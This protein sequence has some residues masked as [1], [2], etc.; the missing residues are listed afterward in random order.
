M[1][2]LARAEALTLVFME[3]ESSGVLSALW[4][5]DGL[6]LWV[7]PIL[8]LSF[9]F[10]VSQHELIHGHPFR[11]GVSQQRFGPFGFS[12]VSSLL[13]VQIVSLEHHA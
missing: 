9:A 1:K 13:Q 3:F 4:F 5:F 12:P 7:F 2:L 10:W 8:I 6:G 11:S